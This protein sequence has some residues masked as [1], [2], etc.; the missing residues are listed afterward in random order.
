MKYQTLKSYSS[1]LHSSQSSLASALLSTPSGQ[2][3]APDQ[4][5]PG[6]DPAFIRLASDAGTERSGEWK[7]G[8]ARNGRKAKSRQEAVCPHLN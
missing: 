3:S 4:G 8:Q 6:N 2:G 7:S 1:V 5:D